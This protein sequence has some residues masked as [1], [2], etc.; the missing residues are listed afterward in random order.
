[1]KRT[2]SYTSY[3][4]AA[5]A[6]MA[7]ALLKLP[8]QVDIGLGLLFAM[9]FGVGNVNRV[10]VKWEKD[11]AYQKEALD[12][13]NIAIKEKA[14]NITGMLTT[15]LLGISLVAFVCMGYTV[16]ALV[17]GG[18]ILVQLVSLICVSSLL[19]KKM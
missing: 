16:P 18:I 9:A 14:G 6:L 7:L 5:M 15:T 3:A 19:E 12:E 13:R 11:G 4:V 8:H 2:I 10:L 1:M 17:V